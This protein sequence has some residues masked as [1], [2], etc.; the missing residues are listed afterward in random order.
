MGAEAMT[1]TFYSIGVSE[2]SLDIKMAEDFIRDPAHGAETSFVGVV[3]DLNMG[4]K[5]DGVSYDCFT[6]LT[7]TIFTAL[8]EEVSERWGA[9]KVYCWHFKGR[10]DVG[11][12]SIVI[13]VSTPHRDEAFQACR[14]LIEEIKHRAPIWKK[15]HYQD[16]DSEWTEGCE[17]CGHDHI[18]KGHQH[19]HDGA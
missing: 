15:E 10:L 2:Q 6:P 7:E 3:R 8:A 11:G 16:G 9:M 14:Y 18:Y 4:R 5:V 1:D 13:A 17:L 19:T 12:V